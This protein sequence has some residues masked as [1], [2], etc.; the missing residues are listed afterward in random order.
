MS[1]QIHCEF[2]HAGLPK[3]SSKTAI[4]L[5]GKN[6][7]TQCFDQITTASGLSH[8]FSAPPSSPIRG[9]LV[10]RTSYHAEEGLIVLVYIPRADG[11]GRLDVRSSEDSKFPYGYKISFTCPVSELL[12]IESLALE[13]VTSASKPSE[14]KNSA[15]TERD[16]N[17][18]F[19][20]I[21]NLVE[22]ACR[23]KIRCR[24]RRTVA[25]PENLNSP[26]FRTPVT[27]KF[28]VYPASLEGFHEVSP[29]QEPI[30]INWGV[31][32]LV[33][34]TMVRKPHSQSSFQEILGESRAETGLTAVTPQAVTPRT[35]TI[36]PEIKVVPRKRKLPTSFS[37]ATGDR[38]RPCVNLSIYVE[39]LH[40]PAGD[41]IHDDDDILDQE[42]EGTDSAI[43][44]N[45][46][47]GDGNDVL[48]KT[49]PSWQDLRRLPCGRVC[50]DPAFYGC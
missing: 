22:N 11:E 2:H 50:F 33:G 28:N 21:H 23:V 44:K 41:P 49:G 20:K 5:L 8:V 38:K 12:E 43:S 48:L 37:T 26:I 32:S 40:N 13:Y 7:P 45:V 14:I 18:A 31:R 30:P 19:R 15:N 35:T 9:D 42:Q 46:I 1:G 6:T 16:T 25:T 17:L 39:D 29:T 27:P 34:Q 4:H 36:F 3:G 24:Q 47:L 10:Y